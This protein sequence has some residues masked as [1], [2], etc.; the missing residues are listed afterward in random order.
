MSAFK[1]QKVLNASASLIPEM[2]ESIRQEFLKD[3]FEVNVDTLLNGGRDISISKGGSFKAIL[4]MRSALKVTLSPHTDGVAFEASVGIFGQQ[5]IPTII[6]MF[7]FAPVLITQI[8]GMV[9]QS[10]LDDRALA[11][12][13]RV[14]D[15]AAT[16]T[17]STAPTAN[18]AY[19]VPTGSKKFYTNCGAEV[20]ADTLFCSTCG[21]KFEN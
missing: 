19:Q 14:I 21:N 8:W 9:K 10:K 16:S 1:Q 20:P 2:A 4:G 7:W 17:A 13:E 3:N 5:F 11:A 12:A 6:S 15:S 18:A